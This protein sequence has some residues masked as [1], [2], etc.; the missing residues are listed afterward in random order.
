MSL[1][2][3]ELYRNVFEEF[4]LIS[5]HFDLTDNTLSFIVDTSVS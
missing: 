1:F 5:V 3:A 2:L 4:G